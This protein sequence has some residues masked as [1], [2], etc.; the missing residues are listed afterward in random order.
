[1]RMGLTISLVVLIFAGA[2]WAACPSM[3]ITGD[4][5]VNFDDFAVLASEWLTT[6]DAIDLADMA[7][8]WL[9]NGA[10]VTTW[11]TNFGEGTTVTLA[12]AG[13]VDAVIYWGDGTF[14]TVTVPG[15]HVHDYGVDGL[16][17]VSVT[18]SVTAYNSVD[19]GGETSERRKLLSVDNWGQMG[20]SSMNYAFYGC[21]NLISVPATSEGI[22]A[23]NDMSYMFREA[24]SFNH[25]IG[26][27]DTSSVTYM[28]G[29][30]LSASAFSQDIGGWNTS[31]VTDMHFMFNYAAS[32]N[33]D[34]GGWDTSSI[35]NMLGMFWGASL[36]NQDIGGWNTSSVCD[37]S[38]IF[39]SA[40]SF[41]Q[42]IGGWDTSS[43]SSMNRMFWGASS[44]NQNIEGWDTS[45]VTDMSDMF[46]GASSFNQA[47][48]GWDTSS[49]TD[50]TWMFCHASSFNETIGNW[51]TSRVNRMGS[52]F[53]GASL[54]NQDIGGWVTSS[55]TNM[56][57]MFRDA[58]SFNQDLSGWCV[59]QVPLE[60]NRSEPYYFDNGATSWKLPRPI[61]E[62][63]S[64]DFVTTWDTNLG[65]GTT[66]TLALAGEVNATID[67]GDGTV[68]NVF[69]PGPHVHDYGVD[70]IYTVS[71]VGRA[72]AYNS[73][74]NG[75][76]W[77]HSE[78]A[79]LISVDNWEQLGLTSMRYAFYECS[80]LV[81]V[82]DISEG[83]KDVTD[84]GFMFYGATSFN[85]DLSG[86]CVTQIPSEPTDFDIGASSW[87]LPASRPIW[88][89]CYPFITTWDTSLGVGT[90]VTLALAGEVDATINWG[91]GTVE[92]V[93]TPG[94]HVHDY[95]VDGIYTV[96]VSGNVTE[97]NSYDN[98]GEPSEREK[99]VSVDSWGQ[100]GFTS[101]QNAFY[102]CSNLV[103]VP[104]TSDG[105]EAVTDMS[106]LFYEASLFNQNIGGWKTSTVTNMSKMFYGATSFNQNIGGWK[107]SMVTNM[108][109]MFYGASSFNQK[110]VYWDTSNVTDMSGMFSYA[111]SFNHYIGSWDTS[112]VTDLSGMFS[113]ALSFNQ[114]IGYWD[115]SSVINMRYMFH[116][117]SS[118]NQNL[119]IW[120]V[121]KI[122]L[123]PDY[124]DVG[125]SSWT[126]PDSRPYWGTCPFVTT[127]DTRLG[128]GRMV[129]L[130]LAGEVY[131]TIDWGDRK[132]DT[133]TAPGPHWHYYGSEG[134]YTVSVYGWVGAYNSSDNGG[135]A[136]Q[137]E[138]L[139]SVDSWGEVGF[140]NMYGAFAFC[141]NLISVPGTSEGIESV[142]DM[143]KMFYAANSFNQNIG[144]WNTSNVT[145]MGEMFS[146]A[147]LF[148]QDIGGWDTSSV[149][150]MGNMFSNASSFNQDIGGWDTSSVTDMS[151]MFFG[152][153]SFNHDISGW[154]T[155][156]VT[157]MRSMFSAASMF[158][159]DIGG[160]DTSSVTNMSR[161]FDRASSFNQDL[162]GW[163]V[164]KIPSK[165]DDFDHSATSWTLSRPIWGTCPSPFVTT[166]DTR[167]GDG[168]TVTLALAG[169]VDAVINWGVG[170]VEPVTTPGPHVHDYGVDGIYTISVTGSVTSY[171][172]HDNGGKTSERDKLISVDNW[173]QLGFTSM[174]CAFAE[175]SNLYS[176]PGI[177][178]GIELVTDM[179]YMFYGAS[180]FNQDL[181]GW[182]VTKIPTEPTD[183]DIGATSWTLSRPIWGTCPPFVT[184]WNTNL[185]D[186]TTVTLGLAGEVDATIDWGDGTVETVTTP[187]PHVHDYG[188]DGIYTV[189][190]TGSVTAYNS[191][192][193]GGAVSE[194]KKLISADNWGEVGFISM[195]DAFTYCSNLISVPGTSEGIEAVT[196]MSR[197]FYLARSFNL[198][199]GGWNT[200]SVTKMSNM[201]DSAYSFNQDIG[202]WDTSS[203]TLMSWM[204]SYASSFNHDIGGWDTSSVT[205]MN[206]MFYRASAFN[207]NIG[208]WDTSSVTDM[209]AMFGHASVFN[210][211][212]S[213]WDTS[214][215]TEMR[216]MFSNA[217]S[218]NQDIGGWDTSSVTNMNRM[219]S[220]A[221]AFKQDLSGW[222][223]TKITSKPDDFDT[224]ATSWTLR[225]SRP[226]W[227]ATCP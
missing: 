115:T 57:H 96:W 128:E 154:E 23:V 93:T 91:D 140:T 200:S 157:E 103:S 48:G 43:V 178:D 166:W 77:P 186:G 161:M 85:Q 56:S 204:F 181:S 6:Y 152:V 137:R 222:C 214:S 107:T 148:N 120:Y 28:G 52:M 225:D 36:F 67:W 112:S 221:W 194:R 79:K 27:W 98:G 143:S 18:G 73:L 129:T 40:L 99:L 223:V 64:P 44:F 145:D 164:T 215:V 172:S 111:S 60:F 26:R 177:S 220:N 196:D 51:D 188:V 59:I 54:F 14:E 20:F 144:G 205:D 167:L 104:G 213:G 126:L 132:F 163:C 173:G 63:C 190:V 165:P 106:G 212:I 175:C 206:K 192:D 226:I 8:E 183:F 84:M 121:K 227:G 89:T 127:W 131:A 136:T 58:S 2:A 42:D 90:M 179:S 66:V 46:H 207:G 30:F 201:F 211:D 197:M 61:W 87:T 37:M 53:S 117:A 25:D 116:E 158:N 95:G 118:F 130:A 110:I 184:T 19:N 123:R 3:D 29:M 4:C 209:S 7:D 134:I 105:I 100:V 92:T 218:F 210:Q 208:G 21:S 176:V 216:S 80:N 156:S 199:I 170:D 102:C 193:N 189:L 97:Y 69:T 72:T 94:P 125:A 24:R 160:W 12:L 9:D 151:R 68:K 34:I 65:D 147:Y 168:T 74:D 135:S 169:E 49:V 203:V 1:M 38:W 22:E 124:F 113:Y 108:S 47:I 191:Y 114:N 70:G 62:T 150:D 159:R 5:R 76:G 146:G 122:P 88:G 32:F 138:K 101:M 180:S 202:G 17:T 109:N 119:S 142:T 10:F 86:W 39:A 82:P 71:V 185:E 13:E 15:P 81:S 31:S 16:Y 33:Q 149:T 195:C 162:S 133:V 198:D 41:N 78:E 11:D 187:G 217:S 153:S 75:G 174:Y 35:I 224:D 139:I 182:C 219:F 50:M 55:V 83:I 155:S 141:R 171:N 45:S